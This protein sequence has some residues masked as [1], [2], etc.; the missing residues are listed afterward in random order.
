MAKSPLHCF[1][2]YVTTSPPHNSTRF[3]ITLI[4]LRLTSEALDHFQDIATYRGFAMI[5]GLPIF[6]LSYKGDDESYLS[7]SENRQPPALR[8]DFSPSQL[9]TQLQ[10]L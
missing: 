10:Y 7:F 2:S 8:R 6:Y 1:A 5:K 9:G 4:Q 3:A